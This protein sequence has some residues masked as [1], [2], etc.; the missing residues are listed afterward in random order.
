MTTSGA[1]LWLYLDAVTGQPKGPVSLVVLKKLLRK[2]IVQPQQ[3]VWTKHLSEWAAIVN[4]EPLAAYCHVWTMLWYYTAENTAKLSEEGTRTGPVT[5]QRLVQLF[6]DGEVDGMTLVWNQE[7]DG[8]KP[9]GEVPSLKEFLQEAND[10]L[11]REI[12]LQ[13]QASEVP[14]EHQVF[15]NKLTDALVA[16][17][18]KK[19]VFDTESKTYITPEDKIEEEL[20][21][22]QEAVAEAKSEKD[23]GQPCLKDNK[24]GHETDQNEKPIASIVSTPSAY[25]TN[26]DVDAAKKRKKKKKKKS[27]K[28][29]R[30]RRNT[31]A[32]V[33]GLP[34]DVT[35]QE[36]HDHF[37][38]CGV[39]QSDI[40]TGEPRIKLYPNRESGGLNGDGSVCYMKEAS[41]ELAVQLLDKSQIRPKWPIDVCPAEFQ[42]KGEE[43]VKRKKNKIDT[44]A[45]IRMFEKEKALSWNEGEVS[46]PAGLRIVVIKHM[47]TPAEIEDEAYEKE[48][49]EDIYGECS[50]IGEVSKITLF[51]KHMDG[52]VAIKFASSG[53]AARCV[54][55]MNGRF[56]AGRKLECGFWDGT[57]Y[58]HREST[59]EEKERADKFQEWLEEGSSSSD[60]EAND[61]KQMKQDEIAAGEKEARNGREIPCVADGSDDRDVKSNDDVDEHEDLAIEVHMDR[62]MPDPDDLDDE[63]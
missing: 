4:V 61:E 52:V 46:E 34:L 12:E 16:E 8:W 9:I 6:V 56:F 47:F 25:E 11:N 39:I 62:V 19:Y 20:A 1:K 48:L 38:K 2:G 15:E 60:S 42:Q 40:V 50:K 7:L 55:I 33:N 23:A 54:E 24:D 21:S 26:V 18:G 37:A 32:Y 22:L 30:S 13:E 49:Q 5:T 3:L 44:R 31:W 36:V 29:K 41:V 53:S 17:D 45:K 10:D 57:D 35:V 43:F 28:W 27:D 58:T 59:N 14:M 63:K 51:A